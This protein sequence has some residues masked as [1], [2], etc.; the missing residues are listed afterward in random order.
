ML[1]RDAYVEGVSCASALATVACAGVSWV[2]GVGMEDA[3]AAVSSGVPI[4]HA[5]V[6]SRARLAAPMLHRLR[7]EV[8]LALCGNFFSYVGE[9]LCVLRCIHS[10]TRAVVGHA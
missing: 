8:K 5:V 6:A 7:V 2:A 3:G 1:S 10:I 9:I 4:W